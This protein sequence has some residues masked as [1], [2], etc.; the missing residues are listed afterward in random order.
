MTELAKCSQDEAVLS[1]KINSASR[2]FGGRRATVLQQVPK[3]APN[4]LWFTKGEFVVLIPTRPGG[5]QN[6]GNQD[7]WLAMRV[8]RVSF[9]SGKWRR[10]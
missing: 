4:R 9:A 3:R 5:N 7:A 1:L 2:R 10:R 8:G 6:I